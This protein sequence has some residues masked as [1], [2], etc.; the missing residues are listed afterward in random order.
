MLEIYKGFVVGSSNNPQKNINIKA[1]MG[2]WEQNQ[3]SAVA[4]LVPWPEP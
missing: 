3:V 4:N 2:H 1:K